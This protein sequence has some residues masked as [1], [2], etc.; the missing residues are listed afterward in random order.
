M[1]EEYGG[2]EALG[3]D[4]PEDAVWAAF[5]EENPWTVKGT[6]TKLA[7]FVELLRKIERE[8]KQFSSRTFGYAH[9]IT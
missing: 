6:K 8:L 2:L 9:A 4:S 1:I 5:Q 3:T 7:R